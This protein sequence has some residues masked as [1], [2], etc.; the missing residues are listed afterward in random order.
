MQTIITNMTRLIATTAVLAI[1]CLAGDVLASTPPLTIVYSGNLDGE[2]EPC[3]CSDEGNYGGIK[4]R[5]TTL[6]QLRKQIPNLVAISSGG[7]ISSEGPDDMLKSK[8]ILKGF[9]ALGYDAIGMQW[10]DLGFGYIFANKDSLPWVVS[11]WRD[12]T[13]KQQPMARQKS[14]TRTVAGV[15]RELAFFNWLDPSRSPMR[16][17]QGG[18]SVVDDKSQ[19][20]IQAVAA[21]KKQGALTVLAT[22]LPLEL[23]QEQLVLTNVDILFIEANYEIF[24]EPRML[25]TTLVL[26]PG[27][28][29]MRIAQL[30]LQFDDKGRIREWKHTVIPMPESIPDAPRLATWYEEYNAKVKE[31]YLIKAALRKKL[32]AGESDF[33][34]EEKCQ[35]CHQ[36][37]Y[38]IWQESQHAIAYEDLENVNK[39]F[40]PFCIGCHV[41]AFDKEGGFIDISMTGHLMNVQCESCHGAGRKHVNSSGKE[42][43]AN[44]G[45]PKE[46]MCGQCHVQKHSPSF[47]VEK[48]WPKIAH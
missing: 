33:V 23:A 14:I 32:D 7:L 9:A 13:L 28:R 35:T 42:K 25:G 16:E 31:A 18:H 4:R 22:S 3:G 44:V 19:S 45:W 48:Y 26:Q 8:Y 38:K 40:D 15:R 27:S 29:G 5:A 20:M 30:D 34:G 6:D 37:Q 46:K 2:L 1:V 17:M 24:S 36:A 41:V 39:A 11:N 43:V 47:S 12:E 21:A 10:R